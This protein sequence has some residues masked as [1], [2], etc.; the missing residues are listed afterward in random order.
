METKKVI[1]S[2]LSIMVLTIFAW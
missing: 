1:F 2:F